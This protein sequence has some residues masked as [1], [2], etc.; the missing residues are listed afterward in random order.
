MSKRATLLLADT[1]FVIHCLIGVCIV[2]GWYFPAVQVAYITLLIL[3]ISCWIFLGYCPLTKWEFLLR[4]K[5][6]QS[7]D[8]EAEIIQYYAY[9]L[10][11]QRISSKVILGCGIA[12][13]IVLVSASLGLFQ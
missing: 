9:K 2:S 4:R 3:W 5:Y 7:V 6:D 8:P 1:V 10:F 13:F 11:K 12:L